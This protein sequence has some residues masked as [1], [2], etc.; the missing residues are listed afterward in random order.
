MNQ[1]DWLKVKRI[2]S[3]CWRDD[4]K[5]RQ[6]TQDERDFLCH[7]GIDQE[8]ERRFPRLL[9]A[10]K[11]VAILSDSEAH[12]AIN[13]HLFYMKHSYCAS[14]AVEHFC[15]GKST[16]HLVRRAFACRKYAGNWRVCTLPGNSDLALFM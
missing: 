4:G 11:W 5:S 9:H 2:Y 15:S 1:Q 16:D 3:E 7:A 10:M 6:T 12:C 14:E 13:A 8:I